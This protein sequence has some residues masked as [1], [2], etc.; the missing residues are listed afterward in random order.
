M[1]V[2]PSALQRI[3][4]ILSDYET[5]LIGGCV[6]DLLLDIPPK[7][8]DF[9]TAA[10]PTQM[11]E[12]F[13]RHGI[14]TLEIGRAFGT[15]GV[16]MDSQVYEI[17]TFRSE[18]DYRDSRRPSS[19]SFASTL[20]EDT[21]RRDFTINALAYHPAH[22]LIDYHGGRADL[23]GGILR[24]IGAPRER[25]GEDALRILRGVG[26]VS[27]F[28]LR[29]EEGTRAAMEECA[30][31]LSHISGERITSELEKILLGRFW[32]RAVGEFGGIL[33]EVLGREL[34]LSFCA[35]D[36]SRSSAARLASHPSASHSPLVPRLDSSHAT[37]SPLPCTTPPASPL[38]PKPHATHPLPVESHFTDSTPQDSL[39]LPL[40]FCLRL[41]Y[42]LHF[43]RPTS[44]APRPH[45]A[46]P[47]ASRTS[48]LPASLVLSRAQR[49]ELETYLYYLA[50]PLPRSER[51]IC[52]MLRTSPKAPATTPDYLA[53]FLSPYPSA[54]A[55]LDAAL[56]RGL[57]YRTRDLAL[58]GADLL[59]FP[60]ALRGEV[61]T[62]LLILVI[63]GELENSPHALRAYLK[64]TYGEMDSH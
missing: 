57:P 17:T 59:G 20:L 61:L 56:A 33:E 29:A 32:T 49:A 3:F 46:A 58:S 23:R 41:G 8:Y 14:R 16:L 35:S 31:L 42:L 34:D 27:R 11:L 21:K 18:G 39:D 36:F 13:A 50:L 2:L 52:H 22:G 55:L 37:P 40:S 63:D 25:F 10:T 5:Y 24:A 38:S 19:V 47:H 12:I 30:P 44:H 9:T 45:L 6:R 7:D 53:T 48:A 51:E 60:P 28:G 62:R 1:F 64:A 4:A 26:F 15:I 54:R 43:S